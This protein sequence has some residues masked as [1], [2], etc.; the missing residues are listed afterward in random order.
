MSG[1]YHS[2]DDGK[3]HPDW[4]VACGYDY[5]KD[6]EWLESMR[7]SAEDMRAGRV[8]P[9]RVAM[10]PLPQ[11]AIDLLFK[12]A[13]YTWGRRARRIAGADPDPSAPSPESAE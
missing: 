12:V 6:A 4:C 7:R 8:L 5:M 11:W 2:H 9:W 13:P 10:L 1:F 3:L